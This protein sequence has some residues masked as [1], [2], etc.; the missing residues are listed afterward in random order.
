[1]RATGNCYGGI[2]SS[3]YNQIWRLNIM[4]YLVFGSIWWVL[5]TMYYYELHTV[6]LHTSSV[7]LHRVT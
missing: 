1:M 3:Y 5:M 7:V 4:G 6:V 2:K